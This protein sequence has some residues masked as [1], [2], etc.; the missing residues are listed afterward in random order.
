[1]HTVYT[2]TSI[3]QEVYVHCLNKQ[4]YSSGGIYRLFK[5]TRV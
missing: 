3:V 2:K 4:E 5:Q 1:M